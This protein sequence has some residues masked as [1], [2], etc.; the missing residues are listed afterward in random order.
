MNYRISSYSFM[1]SAAAAIVAVVFS[2]AHAEA[3]SYTIKSGQAKALTSISHYD[4]ESCGGMAPPKYKITQTSNGKLSVVPYKIKL[5][6]GPCA[7]RLIKFYFLVYTPKRGFK[8]QDKGAISY[9]EPQFTDSTILS[10]TRLNIVLN[11]K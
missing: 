8:G 4:A 11:V 1:S 10:Q 6:K 5:P 9:T 3:K 7:G 2:T